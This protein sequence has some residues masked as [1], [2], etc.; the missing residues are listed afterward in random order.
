ITLTAEIVD[1]SYVWVDEN[2]LVNPTLNIS[3]I[4]DTEIT[5]KSLEN[6]SE[7]HELVIEEILSD[8][9]RDEIIESAEIEEGSSDKINFQPKQN[10]EKLEYYCEYHPETMRGNIQLIN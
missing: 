2:G 3:S 10:Y 8:G 4:M 7:E 5:V 6:D 1:S 9:D